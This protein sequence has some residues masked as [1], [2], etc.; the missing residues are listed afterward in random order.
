MFRSRLIFALLSAI[1]PFAAFI[2][3]IGY[4]SLVNA[5]FWKTV[6]PDEPM[7]SVFMGL[8]E[9]TQLLT[10]TA[11]A[12]LVGLVLAGFSLSLS[13]RKRI[14]SVFAYVGLL[15]NGLPLLLGLGVLVAASR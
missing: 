1:L 9:L 12:C 11:I 4:Q 14:V 10:V 2:G 6:T 15:M 8:W 3:V 13:G 7:A 5:D